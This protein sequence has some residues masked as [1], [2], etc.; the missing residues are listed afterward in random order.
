MVEAII[1][2][3]C[4]LFLPFLI[5]RMAGYGSLPIS[6]LICFL[7]CYF[8]FHETTLAELNILAGTGIGFI[9]NTIIC[10]CLHHSRSQRNKEI[11]R[12]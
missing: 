8:S 7:F 4:F 5:F 1:I 10:V 3:A 12:E 2:G 9:Y 6:T 11:D